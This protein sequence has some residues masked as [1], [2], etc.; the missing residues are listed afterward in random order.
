MTTPLTYTYDPSDPDLV[1]RLRGEIGDTNVS[2]GGVDA[3]FSD[4]Q[5]LLF[6]NEEGDYN[7]ALARIY[8]VLAASQ[9]LYV[10][11]QSFLNNFTDGTAISIELMKLAS[12]RR[13]MYTEV[14]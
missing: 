4:E 12:E 7:M 11:K 5:L 3:I 9:A 10:G 8:E 13:A 6:Y 14:I 2:N 1:T